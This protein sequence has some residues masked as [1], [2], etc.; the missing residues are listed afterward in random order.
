MFVNYIND[1]YP[2]L[3]LVHLNMKL[4]EDPHGLCCQRS[5]KH[6][7]DLK[8][9]KFTQIVAELEKLFTNCVNEHYTEY[10]FDKGTL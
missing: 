5:K 6:C 1:P 9:K 7:F 8:I 10:K 3:L 4:M 2:S